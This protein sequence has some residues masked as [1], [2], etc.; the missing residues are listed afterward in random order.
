MEPNAMAAS[1]EAIV[2]KATTERLR[3]TPNRYSDLDYDRDGNLLPEKERQYRRQQAQKSNVCDRCWL[4]AT[5]EQVPACGGCGRLA[6]F[7]CH[8]VAP[9]TQAFLCKDC[10]ND[11]SQ[12]KQADSKSTFK[13]DGSEYAESSN[14]DD[15]HG[16]AEE[17]VDRENEASLS[18]DQT[19]L[20]H[21]K[22]DEDEK[23]L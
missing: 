21:E 23:M 1:K 8:G 12:P 10:A 13:Y 4:P 15:A 9:T 7:K 20:G 14:S 18:K 11:S 5:D 3:K 16:N 17:D 22:S 2:V 19:N 6:H